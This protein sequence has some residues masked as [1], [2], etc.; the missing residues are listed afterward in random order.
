MGPKDAFDALVG[1][2]KT[3]EIFL[4][5]EF[6]FSSKKKNYCQLLRCAAERTFLKLI[7]VVKMQLS[8]RP[9]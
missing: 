7:Q 3:I 2:K 4:R 8:T 5:I 9:F 6:T 1:I